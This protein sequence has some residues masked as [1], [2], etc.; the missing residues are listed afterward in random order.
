[1]DPESSL[2]VIVWVA[3]TDAAFKIT[4]PPELMKI[5][6]VPSNSGVLIVSVA[7]LVTTITPL[8]RYSAV[9]LMTL[10]PPVM[11]TVPP[12][13]IVSVV[14]GSPNST[15]TP[16]LPIL[17]EPAVTLAFRP[18]LRT[19]LPAV[20]ILSAPVMF[21]NDVPSTST[22]PEAPLVRPISRLPAETVAPPAMAMA[23]LAVPPMTTRPDAASRLAAPLTTRSPKPPLS[24]PASMDEAVTVA[25]CA[26]VSRPVPWLPTSNEPVIRQLEP[27]PMTATPEPP[28]GA[29]LAM[30]APA[31]PRTVADDVTTEPP[32]R[33]DR[34]PD[35]ASPT[36]NCPE[37][38]SN[39][40]EPPTEAS[41]TPPDIRPTANPW[42][43]AVS[44]PPVC[45]VA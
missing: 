5:P 27:A 13:V 26:T 21:R 25:P 12:L 44:L 36:R 4:I 7:L 30:T 20:P 2:N 39:D 43:G 14:I 15:S 16:P 31:R 24:T 6:P 23:A 17:M 8:F 18:R 35:P 9:A 3:A 11:L 41:P 37:F 22:M 45:S 33:M 38:V 42:A 1:M 34:W 19:A 10:T 29:V 40:F 28:A 32:D